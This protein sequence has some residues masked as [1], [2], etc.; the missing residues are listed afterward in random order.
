MREVEP[1]RE[2]EDETGRVWVVGVRA[3]PG[4]DFKG[5]YAFW[6]RA[7][8]G[9]DQTGVVL[10]DVRWNSEKTARRTLE[11][12]STVELLRRIHWAR[13]RAGSSAGP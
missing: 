6:V 10:D 11:T 12:I 8:E 9:G 4:L 3:R 5:R 2:V 1:M 7:S 13:G